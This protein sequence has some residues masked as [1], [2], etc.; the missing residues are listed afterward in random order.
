M[1]LCLVV[2]VA[3]GSSACARQDLATTRAVD[4]GSTQAQSAPVCTSGQFW[5]SDDDDGSSRMHPGRACIACHEQG[6]GDG[7]G[8][9]DDDDGDGDHHKDDDDAP[10]LVIAGTVYPTSHEPDDCEGSTDAEVDITDANGVVY[11]LEVNSSGN[12]LLKQKDAKSFAMPFS[13][14]VTRG[15]AVRAMMASQTSGDCN[16]CHTQAGENGAPGRILDP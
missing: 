5:S 12:F 3:I 11:K 15:G 16:A 9:H 7:D 13:A 6:G 2:L 4:L 10:A 14:S 8:D 1:R